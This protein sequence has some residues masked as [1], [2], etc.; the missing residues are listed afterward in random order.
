MKVSFQALFWFWRPAEK[1]ADQVEGVPE[2]FRVRVDISLARRRL[3]TKRARDVAP[4]DRAY[5][6][7]NQWANLVGVARAVRGEEADSSRAQTARVVLI[8]RGAE[9]F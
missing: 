4:A 6:S 7:P 2:A 5:Q 1:G 3:K 9:W 8:D